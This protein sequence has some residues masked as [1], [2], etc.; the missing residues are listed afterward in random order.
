MVY[1]VAAFLVLWLLVTGY[2]LF[3]SMRQRQLEQEIS[4]L[5][6]MIAENAKREQ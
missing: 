4:V 1:L 2:V 3:M 5:E 6:E